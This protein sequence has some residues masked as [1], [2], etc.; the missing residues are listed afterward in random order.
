MALDGPVL[1]PDQLSEVCQSFY[2][3][4]HNLLCLGSASWLLE[5]IPI[6]EKGLL[7]QGLVLPVPPRP[8]QH[9]EVPGSTG[10]QQCRQ[11]SVLEQFLPAQTLGLENFNLRVFC[12]TAD[13]KA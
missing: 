13:H 6:L 1:Y 10:G 4:C 2:P 9:T 8:P 11:W 5:T 7:K 12:P 3:A